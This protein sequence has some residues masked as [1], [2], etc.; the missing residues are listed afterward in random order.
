M[1]F[2]YLAISAALLLSSVHAMAADAYTFE[3]VN[4][5]SCPI[6]YTL[7]GE[8]PQTPVEA[9]NKIV[10]TISNDSVAIYPGFNRSPG[11]CHTDQTLELDMV[12]EGAAQLL[13]SNWEGTS[14]PLLIKGNLGVMTFLFD[15]EVKQGSSSAIGVI[16]RS[17]NQKNGNT[18]HVK[19]EVA[20]PT[21][22]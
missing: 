12:G 15:K 1:K 19:I 6:K 8:G 14:K 4:N 16:N 3:L 22:R 10:R 17:F 9:G 18:R 2:Q 11:R 21:A 20:A 5:G 7:S 13:S